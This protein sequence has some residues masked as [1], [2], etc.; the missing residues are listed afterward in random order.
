METADDVTPAGPVGKPRLGGALR[1][2]DGWLGPQG[3]SGVGA[4]VWHRGRVAAERY[5]GEGRPGAPVDARTIFPLASVTKPV[6]AAVVMTLVEEGL[7]SL[8][9]SVGRLVPEFR[10]DPEAEGL[11][12]ARER[13]RPNITVRQLLAHTSGLPEDLGPREGRYAERVELNT[14]VD[15]MCRLPL[16]SAPG[17]ELRYSNAGYGVLTRLVERLTGQEFWEVARR[18]VLL[19]MRLRDTIARPSPEVTD[20]VALLADTTH[21]GTE[22]ETYNGDYWR[23]LAIPWGGLFGTPRDLAR[24]AGTFLPSGAAGPRLLSPPALRLMTADQAEGVPGGVESARVRWEVAHWGLGWEV[25]GGKRRHW[26]GEL[27]SPE[28]FCH[29]GAAGTLLWADPTQDLALAVFAN[30]AVA[31][32]WTFILPRWARLSNAVVAAAAE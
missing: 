16:V 24:F 14:I 3:A 21:A 23:G 25:K 29:F 15:A 11:D 19:P 18:R 4:V 13:L 22:L 10:A 5:A 8:D 12:P 28:T 9:E 2:I 26:T 27:T 32:I 6:T 17:S 7:V 30:R 20:R 1:A 31:R